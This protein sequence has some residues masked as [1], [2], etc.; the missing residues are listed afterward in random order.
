MLTGMVGGV[1]SAGSGGGKNTT[2]DP[3]G[4]AVAVIGPIPGG[5]T[6]TLPCVQLTSPMA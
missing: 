5:V 4:P 1:G 3:Y 6:V 2:P